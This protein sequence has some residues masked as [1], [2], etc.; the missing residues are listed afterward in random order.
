MIFVI[1]SS[2]KPY[3]S[4]LNNIKLIIYVFFKFILKLTYIILINYC[5]ILQIMFLKS[6]FNKNLNNRS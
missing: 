6:H 3:W 1:K 4:F 5:I 2:S